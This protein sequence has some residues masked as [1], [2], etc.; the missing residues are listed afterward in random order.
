MPAS[1]L[2]QRF[3]ES[4][5]NIA[6]N[7]LSVLGIMH[8]KEEQKLSDSLLRW[9][10]FRLRFVDPKPRV[11]HYSSKF[12]VSL[13][14]D[15]ASA[16]RTFKE[17]VMTGRDVNPYQGK[18]LSHHHDTSDK[19]RQKRTDLLW[20]DWGIHHFHLTTSP[21]VTGK[22]Y[23]PR[24]DWLLFGLFSETEAAFVDVRHHSEQNV[25]E[26]SELIEIVIREWPSFADHFR[27]KGILPGSMVPTSHDIKRL[28]VAGVSSP[29][30]VDG[31]AYAPLGWGVTTASTSLGVSLARN[32]VRTITRD[33]ARS[34]SDPSGQFQTD[35]EDINRDC[36]YFSLALTARGLGII[37]QHS[38]KCWL[39]PRNSKKGLPTKLGTLHDLIVP[40]WLC[41]KW[42]DH[43]A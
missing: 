33:L 18:G 19:K 2:E 35:I 13:P 34:V 4:L 7:L 20:A 17:S 36:A 12:P 42:K 41:A 1:E 29:V 15:I 6:A 39:L 23:S 14:T 5:E 26:N 16:L 11:I 22:Y 37:E 3:F 43:N 9:I 38:N 21:P 24:S 8:K 30:I 32:E 31:I 10:D 40:E 25:F 28:R 27:M